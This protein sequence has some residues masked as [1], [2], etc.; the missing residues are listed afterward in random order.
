MTPHT[1]LPRF[2]FPLIAAA[3]P[4]LLLPDLVLPDG[5]WWLP[6]VAVAACACA[7]AWV[8]SRRLQV[9]VGLL[10]VATMAGWGRA[11]E[12]AEPGRHLGGAAAG[13]LLMAAVTRWSVDRDRL[14]AALTATVMI[15]IAAVAVGIR[16]TTAPGYKGLPMVLSP[17][18]NPP[19]LPFADVLGQPFVNPNAI[20]IAA[21]MLACLSVAAAVLSRPPARWQFAMRAAGVGGGLIAL[22]VI[23]VTQSRS[24]L[25]ALLVVGALTLWAW[26][27]RWRRAAAGVAVVG[28]VCLAAFLAR[29]PQAR[30]GLRVS[31]GDRTQHWSTASALLAEHPWRGI[32]L[33]GYRREAPI[34]VHAHN[35][36]LQTA[37]DLGVPG[38]L[39][40]LAVIVMLL[41]QA[42][43]TTRL[44]PEPL[45]RAIAAGAG[46]ALLAVHVYGLFDAVAFGTRIGLYQWAAAGLILGAART[47]TDPAT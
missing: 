40:Y 28:A 16:S 14:A 22:P 43:R 15:G 44:G 25:L 19:A 17:I 33:N 46:L 34:Q 29:D 26:R 37:L 42:Q 8:P 13:L 23:A 6:A 31:L 41:H 20:G 2:V 30:A 7:T 35:V 12:D 45:H 21:L 24:V 18:A 32:G 38:A 27:P 3:L 39:A 9:A 1:A 4:V 36:L 10:A 47:M 5:R 11:P